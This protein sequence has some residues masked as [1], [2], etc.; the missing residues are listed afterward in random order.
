ME[1]IE[2]KKKI[3]IK[4]AEVRFPLYSLAPGFVH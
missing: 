2:L 4:I 1:V 3:E